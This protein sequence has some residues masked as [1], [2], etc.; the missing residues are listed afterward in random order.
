[1]EDQVTVC[2]YF[3]G[4]GDDPA[5]VTETI[6]IEPTRSYK[7]GDELPLKSGGTWNSHRTSWR[8]YS[9]LP[10]TA[11]AEDHDLALL[12]RLEPH[13]ER[14]RRASELYNGAV[15]IGL[16]SKDRVFGFD[17]G[18]DEVR[19]L[20]ALGLGLTTD[21]YLFANEVGDQEAPAPA[22]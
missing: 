4:Y 13:A 1:M 2:L 18:R 16:L 19:R 3:D 15:Q 6:G 11:S 10:K 22:V 12:D 20:A 17:L 9:P 21:L 5:V 7:N 14:V 8:L